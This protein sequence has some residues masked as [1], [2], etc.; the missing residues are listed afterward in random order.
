MLLLSATFFSRVASPPLSGAPCAPGGASGRPLPPE[1][2]GYAPCSVW[3]LPFL[4]YPTSSRKLS[5]GGRHGVLSDQSCNPLTLWS[6][7]Y[8]NEWCPNILIFLY[9]SCTKNHC[10]L[11]KL[12]VRRQFS[13][14][15]NEFFGGSLKKNVCANLLFPI[16]IIS[17]RGISYLQWSVFSFSAARGRFTHDSFAVFWLCTDDLCGSWPSH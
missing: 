14:M 8:R 17:Y 15:S 16:R 13:R 6:V 4:F 3:C 11:E 2:Y 1:K 9:N 5:G 12:F 7:S 10:T